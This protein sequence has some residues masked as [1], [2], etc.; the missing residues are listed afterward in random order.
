MVFRILSLS[1]NGYAPC[2]VKFSNSS[3]N[4]NEYRWN[5][6]DPESGM[7]NLSTEKDPSHIF[8]NGGT[9][10]IILEGKI[11]CLTSATHFTRVLKLR[12]T[13]LPRLISVFRLPGKK[14]PT[15]S[16]LPTCQKMRTNSPGISGILRPAQKTIPPQKP[17]LPLNIKK[18]AP[19]G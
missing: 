2:E 9:Y 6:G 4:V 12:S 3:S 5:F 10:T 13:N 16:D 17:I 11:P 18:P 8:K 14:H 15:K 1:N 19:I 7:N